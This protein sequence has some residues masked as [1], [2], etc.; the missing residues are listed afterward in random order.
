MQLLHPLHVAVR[1]V[2]LPLFSQM[3]VWAQGC[4]AGRCRV[5]LGYHR[6]CLLSAL[7]MAQEKVPHVSLWQDDGPGAL[8]GVQVE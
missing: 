5:P 4:H 7:C 8:A 2:F 3:G 1:W 6:W